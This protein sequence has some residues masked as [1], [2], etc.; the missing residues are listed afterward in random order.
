MDALRMPW[1]YTGREQELDLV[2]RSIG[3]GRRGIVITGGPGTGKTRIMREATH[4]V[5]HILVTGSR[6]L[7]GTPLAAFAAVLPPG[8]SPPTAAALLS[9]VRVLAVD[10]AH[11]LD[12][13]SA[14]MIRMLAAQGPV[15]VLVL[16]DSSRPTPDHL[17]WLW[18]EDLLPCLTLA[19]LSWKDADR[20]LAGVLG[21]PVDALTVRRLH[22]ACRGDLVLLRELVVG[23]FDDG[24]LSRQYGQW[25]WRGAVPVSGR[26]CEIMDA[27]IGAV[28]GGERR[29]LELLAFG[30]EFTPVPE[31]V[32]DRLEARGLITDE[33]GTVRIAHPLHEA[34]VRVRASRSRSSMPDEEQTKA[35]TAQCEELRACIDSGDVRELPAGIG[36]W[37][38]HEGWG[39]NEPVL[40]AEFCALRACAA[41]LRG[42]VREAVG[43]SRAGLRYRPGDQGCAAEFA[44]AAIY[45]GQSR[46][47]RSVLPRLPAAAEALTW[48][49]AA[50]G[51]T[52]A[53]LD[54]CTKG[55]LY[56][57]H[58]GAR[59]GAGEGVAERLGRS[60]GA[61]AALLAAHANALIA[62]DADALDLVAARFE[63][64]GL[65]LFAAEAAAQ[66]ANGHRDRRAQR[67]S[68]GHATSLALR[69]QGARTPILV[70]VLLGELTLRQRQIVSLAAAGMTNREI[71][72][73]LTLSIRT[74]ANH[75][76][77]AYVRLGHSDR[78]ALGGLFG[79][80]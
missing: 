27:S 5:D 6:A 2:R 80:G 23:I 70:S 11:L 3:S 61:F 7:R 77:A 54:T 69:C 63:E 67:S 51:N 45:L 78:A 36:E 22:N 58:N 50:E 55:S 14:S 28:D 18:K 25:T 42:E 41:R 1:P 43:W 29:A 35:L 73:Q 21:G 46:A 75:L 8:V 57:L 52:R 9:R 44:H 39:E 60:E 19:P 17:S 64:R 49:Q 20:M 40:L 74:V 32:L 16:I 59:L 15:R 38:V 37:L 76:C 79:T 53:A 66:A 34:L 33:R 4:G 13:A 31:T 68:R 62:R 24:R 71:A 10:D 48:L 65:L 26:L 47:A 30:K 12:E 56:A 72:E